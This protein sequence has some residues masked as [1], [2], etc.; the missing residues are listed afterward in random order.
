MN[1]VQLKNIT[2][3]F[4]GSLCRPVVKTYEQGGK[5]IE[6][7]YWYCPDSGRFIMKGVVSVTAKVKP[8][9]VEK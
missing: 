8:N 1:I 5:V 3:P 2:S 4:S 9:K 6:E 7:A